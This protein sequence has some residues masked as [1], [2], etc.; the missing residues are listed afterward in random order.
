MKRSCLL[1]QTGKLTA[2]AEEGFSC[3]EGAVDLDMPADYDDTLL[4]QYQD[5]VWQQL[6]PPKMPEVKPLTEE[7]KAEIATLTERN[8]ALETAILELADQVLGLE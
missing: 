1:D 8:E 3:G 2:V 4:W 7:L 6:P 5:G